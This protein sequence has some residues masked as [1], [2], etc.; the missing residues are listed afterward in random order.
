MTEIRFVR[1][2]VDDER[3]PKFDSGNA[4]VN[5][6]SFEQSR[7][8]RREMLA[9]S[10]NWKVGGRTVAF[11]S[12]SNDV[13]AIE[14]AK[15][16]NRFWRPFPNAKRL[17]IMPAVKIG[18]FAVDASC[19]RMRYG[20]TVMDFIRLWF[21]S[22]NKTGCRFIILDA[23]NDHVALALYEQNGFAYLN[24]DD[25]EKPTRLMNF[26]LKK[27]ASMKAT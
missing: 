15:P 26:D 11:F 13:I 21:V 23:L 7:E 5:H 20:T 17:R 10:Y 18:R 27:I 16:R 9:V 2:G 19:R 14:Q 6:F 8:Y 22:E 25:A 24:Q 1:M 12:F 3:N 4:E